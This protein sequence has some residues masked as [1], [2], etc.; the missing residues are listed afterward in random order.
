MGTKLEM[1]DRSDFDIIDS[2]K[3]KD[4]FDKYEAAEGKHA[5]EMAELHREAESLEGEEKKLKQ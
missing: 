2:K 1:K 4:T 5:K 3:L